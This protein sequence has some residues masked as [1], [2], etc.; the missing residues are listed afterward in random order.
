MPAWPLRPFQR[1]APPDPPLEPDAE[2]ALAERLLP[3]A[4]AV[5]IA[6]GADGREALLELAERLAPA[7]RS[8][9]LGPPDLGTDV[10]TRLLAQ[11]FRVYDSAGAPRLSVLVLDSRIGWRLPTWDPIP[12][13]FQVAN[14]LMW[15][16]L[17]YYTVLRGTVDE[18]HAQNR[19]FSFAERSLWVNTAYR[20][21][22]MPAHG[23]HV[24][25]VGMYSFLGSTV[26]IFHALRITREPA[27]EHRSA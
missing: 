14:R 16:R 26:P 10:I 4:R 9:V 3:H 8:E 2:R 27:D 11:G 22:A 7:G 24:A 17:G 23:A 6:P 21:L 25:V 19:M 20:D 1:R 13:A 12:N 18:I 5:L 15:T